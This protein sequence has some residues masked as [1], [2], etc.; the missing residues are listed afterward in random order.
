MK[1]AKAT[2]LY[3]YDEGEMEEC[4]T[5]CNIDDNCSAFSFTTDNGECN[6]WLGKT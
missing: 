6:L 4:K 1:T 3:A 2:G 5:F